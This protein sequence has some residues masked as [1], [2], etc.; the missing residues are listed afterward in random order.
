MDKKAKP[1]DNAREAAECGCRL[2]VAIRKAQRAAEER[3]GCPG[4]NC[5]CPCH[6]DEPRTP[7]A[8]REFDA[9]GHRCCE[10]GGAA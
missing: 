9:P 7:T 1:V 3:M 2:H 4:K 10:T 6:F 8:A 5:G